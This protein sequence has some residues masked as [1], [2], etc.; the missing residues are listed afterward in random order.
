[1]QEL[2]P[3]LEALQAAADGGSETLLRHVYAKHP[4]KNAAHRLAEEPTYGAWIVQLAG[5][6]CWPG[7]HAWGLPAHCLLL[8]AEGSMLGSMAVAAWRLLLCNRA[9]GSGCHAAW[10]EQAACPHFLACALP[11]A[12]HPCSASLALSLA[13]RPPQPTSRRCSSRQWSTTTPTA[14]RGTARSGEP[15][16]RCL[17][18]GGGMPIQRQGAAPANAGAAAWAMIA[19]WRRCL[20]L[21]PGPR[22]FV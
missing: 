16:T 20:V 19:G 18:A 6:S 9:D 12:Q 17:R 3:E 21:M 22:A 7:T 8:V 4:P 2:K 15:S 11:L 13:S 5:P 14:R 1:M 10:R